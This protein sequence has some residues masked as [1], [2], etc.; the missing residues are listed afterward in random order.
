MDLHVAG[1][2]TALA[3]LLASR[4]R[5]VALSRR[6]ERAMLRRGGARA[7]GSR[8]PLLVALHA[9]FPLALVTEV[10]AAGVRPG[11]LWP[12]WLA[13]WAVAEWLRSASMRALGDRWSARIVVVPGEPP[14]RS[15][16]YRWFAH[17][18]YLAV[19]LE[20]AA[21]PLLF[22]AWRTAL[23]AGIA[24]AVLVADRIRQEGRALRAGGAGQHPDHATRD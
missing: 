22:G 21:L 19:T 15:G 9:A 23:A 16:I 5:E 11:P 24:N 17:P 10:V 7:A 4:L 1:L 13:L 6:N 2:G 14:I 12:L 20:L 18:S 3:V 8:F